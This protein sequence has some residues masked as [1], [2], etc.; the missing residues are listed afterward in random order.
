M[1]RLPDNLFQQPIGFLF[2]GIDIGLDCLQGARGRAPKITG[3]GERMARNVVSDLIK[4]GYLKS[5]STRAPLT[6][7]FPIDAVERWFSRL[8]PTR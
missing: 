5:D 7:A 1:L 3:Y 8:Y 4:K 2:Q 6:L